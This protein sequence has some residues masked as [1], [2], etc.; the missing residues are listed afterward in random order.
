MTARASYLK[1]ETDIIEWLRYNQNNFYH[2]ALLNGCFDY[3]TAGHVHLINTAAITLNPAKILVAVNSDAS[4]QRLKGP[5]RPINTL[6]DRVDVLRSLRNVDAV[7]LFQEDTPEKLIKL[8]KPMY[9]VKGE[10][11]SQKGIVGSDFVQSY[12]GQ[13][14]YIPMYKDLSTTKLEKALKESGNDTK[15]QE[16]IPIDERNI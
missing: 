12:S 11:Y 2:I 10:E 9:L 15:S 16:K 8:V 7:T 3:L 4:V 14:I 5:A 6:E 13:V 1:S